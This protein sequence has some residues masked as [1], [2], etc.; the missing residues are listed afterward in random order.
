MGTNLAR[1]DRRPASDMRGSIRGTA[2]LGLGASVLAINVTTCGCAGGIS[3]PKSFFWE[4]TSIFRN[5][6]LNLLN[7]QNSVSPLLVSFVFQL[8]TQHTL[9]TL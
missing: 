5:L 3:L 6:L 1:G 8:N 2:G 4:M 9:S 7:T